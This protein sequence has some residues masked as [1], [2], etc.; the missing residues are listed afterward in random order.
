MRA[1]WRGASRPAGD[2][3]AAINGS[4][5][6]MIHWTLVGF[7]RVSPPGTASSAA[8]PSDA[9]SGSGKANPAM[10]AAVQPV[11]IAAPATNAAGCI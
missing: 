11:T 6:A 2:A 1:G 8:T 5:G 7:V 9:A 4:A 10:V 3:A